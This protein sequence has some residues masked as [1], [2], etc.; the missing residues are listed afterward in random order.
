ME[1]WLRQRKSPRHLAWG[2]LSW[3]A[4]LS[5]KTSAGRP[6][7]LPAG[8]VFG[9]S[10]GLVV[11]NRAVNYLILGILLSQRQRPPTRLHGGRA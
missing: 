10:G 9:V 1:N 6:S 11:V 3:C 5:C 8:L 4:E 2:L 7:E